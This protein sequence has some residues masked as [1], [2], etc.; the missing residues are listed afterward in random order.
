MALL[1]HLPTRRMVSR[2]TGA[3]RSAIAP[4]AR[5]DQALTPSGVKPMVGPAAQTMARM[6]VVI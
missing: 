2:S 5:R 3:I 4:P 6:D 1:R